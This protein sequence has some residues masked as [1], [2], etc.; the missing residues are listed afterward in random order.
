MNWVRPAG[1]GK[2]HDGDQQ[3][4][5]AAAHG[6]NDPV[7]NQFAGAGFVHRGRDRQHA[8]E[9]EDGDPVDAF[10]GIFLTDTLGDDQEQR[11]DRG[12]D[13]QRELLDVKRHDDTTKIRVK[14][15][16]HCFI[17][18]GVAGFGFTAASSS[19]SATA[20]AFGSRCLPMKI[21]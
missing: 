9:Q 20:P 7:G 15:V 12:G 1:Q 17:E 19:S 13:F 2:Q 18:S 3:R 4:P 11:A 5:R 14:P 16:I 6:A 10:V 8:G 21:M